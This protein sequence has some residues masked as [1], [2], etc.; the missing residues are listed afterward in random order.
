MRTKPGRACLRRLAG[1]ELVCC[2]PCPNRPALRPVAMDLYN[3]VGLSWP[4]RSPQ[5]S[6]VGTVAAARV[7]YFS[8][9]SLP[10]ILPRAIPVASGLNS[11]QARRFPC[12]A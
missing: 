11:A 3:R 4:G 12:E 10:S 8:V 1:P 6:N 2:R 5:M 9:R 7:V